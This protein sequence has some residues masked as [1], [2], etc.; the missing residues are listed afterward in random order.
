M[1]HLRST[2]ILFVH[3]GAWGSGLAAF[4][5]P[6]AAAYN[7]QG[8]SVAVLGYRTFPDA[9]TEGQV[10]DVHEVRCDVSWYTPL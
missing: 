9:S 5:S 7:K 6:L 1:A 4:Y 8:F 3:G 10:D 2:L